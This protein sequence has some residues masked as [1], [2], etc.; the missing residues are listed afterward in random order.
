MMKARYR[1]VTDRWSGYEVQV[2][3]WWWPFWVMPR[4][5]THTTLEAAENYAR[6]HAREFVVKVLDV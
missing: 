4:V 6:G 1:I 2:W 5:N 3:R